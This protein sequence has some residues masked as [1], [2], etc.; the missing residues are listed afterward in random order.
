MMQESIYHNGCE[1]IPFC[2]DEKRTDD[3]LLFKASKEQLNTNKIVIPEEI[4]GHKIVAIAPYVFANFN[5]ITEI[6]LPDTIVSIGSGAFS[7]C[8]QLKSIKLPKSLSRIDDYMFEFC[9]SLSSVYI[10]SDVEY[11]GSYAFEECKSLSYIN[12]PNSIRCIQPGAFSKCS[13]LRSI[14]IPSEIH[15]IKANTFCGCRNLESIQIPDNIY[16]INKNAFKGCFNLKNVVMPRNIAFIKYN[17]FNGCNNLKRIDFDEGYGIFVGDELCAVFKEKSSAESLKSAVQNQAKFQYQCNDLITEKPL[18]IV[19]GAYLISQFVDLNKGTITNVFNKIKFIYYFYHTKTEKLDYDIIYVANDKLSLGQNNI[20]IKGKKGVCTY[21]LRDVY[22]NGVMTTTENISTEITK[23]PVAKTIEISEEEYNILKKNKVSKKDEANKL[24]YAFPIKN[25]KYYVSS[26]YGYRWGKT[27]GG[28]DLAVKSGSAIQAYRSG[29]VVKAEQHPSYG[30]YIMIDHGNNMQ[31]LYAHCSSL[32]AKKGDVIEQ[33]QVI[34]LSGSTGNST[35]PHLHFEVRINGSRVNPAKYIGLLVKD[36]KDMSKVNDIVKT[37]NLTGNNLKFVNSIKNAAIEAYQH[38]NILPS[39]TIS[40]AILE[41]AWGRSSIGNNI[42]GIKAYSD[43]KGKKKC[44][45]TTEERSNGTRYRT[46]CWFKDYDSI[47][48]SVRDYTK[49]LLGSRYTKVREAGNYREACYA[50]KEAGYA[51]S[52]DYSESLIQLIETYGLYAWDGIDYKID[53][54]D[55]LTDDKS[56]EDKADK[57]KKDD[58]NKK[59]KKSKKKN[60]KKKK[61]NKTKIN[62][63]VKVEA[64][65]TTPTTNNNVTE[66]PQSELDTTTQTTETQNNVSSETFS[67]KNP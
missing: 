21:Q 67:Y 47:E 40:Q 24:S 31:T 39:L 11:I 17:A 62:N 37:K 63:E 46:K 23:Y 2:E 13:N 22:E 45:W 52:S 36:S 49:L 6:I 9:Y 32:L 34:A 60:S 3:F 66:A 48:D 29:T 12:I 42:F 53:G 61:T 7:R 35:G 51:T 25:A 4:N 14:N 64:V 38:Y 26:A 44:V 28:I 55:V 5:N 65:I 30:N 56:T 18:E 54:T 15:Y 57:T 43:W 19:K 10:R 16:S 33:G 27:H 41:S 8:S 20:L 58:K 1:Y 50:V 59:D